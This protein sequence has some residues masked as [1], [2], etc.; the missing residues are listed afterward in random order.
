MTTA[1][2]N[3]DA[4]ETITPE[5]AAELTSALKPN[6]A[7]NVDANVDTPRCSKCSHLLE[8]NESVCGE[9]GYYET[10]GVFVDL[11]E[12]TEEESTPFPWRVF[13][14]PF[15]MAA[16][17]VESLVMAHFTHPESPDR[18]YCS[19]GH[20]LLGMCLFG[21]PHLR[22][23]VKSMKDDPSTGVLNFIFHPLQT[24]RIVV[25]ELPKSFPW[26]LS[27]GVGLAAILC[28]LFILRGLPSPFSEKQIEREKT[29]MKMVVQMPRNR[30][31]ASSLKEA[32]EEVSYVEVVNA[33]EA[34]EVIEE[35]REYLDVVI[36]GFNVSAENP[37]RVHELIIAKEEDGR[38]RVLENV[39][40]EIPE[41]LR[42]EL[43][44]KLASIRTRIP[45]AKTRN[46]AIWVK[47]TYR[48]RV[49]FTSQKGMNFDRM[50]LVKAG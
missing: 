7:A 43:L 31:N 30:S 4:F 19:I 45:A 36:I 10:A 11:E 15:A 27:A 29:K 42:Y 38:L 50:L 14:I 37:D 33:E 22:A 17:V 41:P 35:E 49:W 32:L 6:D 8:V 23:H 18:L 12:E 20:L 1:T 24:W 3:A 46:R 9:C 44:Q 40:R 2:E 13:F 47:P 48:C 21:F 28:S 26:M 39:S 16:V 34:D 5:F 25:R